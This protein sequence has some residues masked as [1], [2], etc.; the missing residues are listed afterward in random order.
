MLGLGFPSPRTPGGVYSMNNRTFTLT[1]LA[2]YSGAKLIGDGTLHISGISTLQEATS[3]QLSFLANPQYRKYLSSTQA[4]AVIL[5]PREVQHFSGNCLSVPNPYAAYAKLTALFAGVVET[6]AKL[7]ASCVHP[8]AVVA[9][10][11]E[12]G[13]GVVIGANAVIESGAQ[14]GDGVSI[15]AGCFVGE[16][17]KIGDS[18][19]LYANVTVYGGIN[20]GRRCVFHSGVV[21]GAD[22]FGFAPTDSGWVKIHHLAGVMIGDDVE[23]GAN[24]CVDRGALSDTV[25]EHGVKTDNMVQIAHGVK[26]GAQTVIA[27]CTAIAGSA[28]IGERCMIA[29]GVGIVGHITIANGVTVTAMSL[30]T[31][32]IKSA[33]SYSSGTPLTESQQWRRSAVRFGQLDEIYQRLRA[34]ESKK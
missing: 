34:L 15:G 33:G 16:G 18:S 9:D 13:Q 32:S 7:G 23:L 4:G 30:V 25:I 5:D 29:G 26:I 24:T 12:I 27:G 8:S 22:G 28:E 14:L 6:E 2:E 21:I 31:K 1:E 20:I 17:T 11:A 19:H 3:S 10:S